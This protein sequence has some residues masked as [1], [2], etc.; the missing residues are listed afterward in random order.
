MAK[1]GPGLPGG[2]ESWIEQHEPEGRYR[3][4]FPTPPQTETHKQ[5]TP[6]GPVDVKIYTSRVPGSDF[7]SVHQAVPADR[8]GL[9][10]DHV[11]DQVAESAR[12]QPGA[13]HNRSTNSRITYP[14]CPP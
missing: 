3:V 13:G 6:A 7:V 11:L 4:K 2:I 8:G 5:Q 1:G 10:D 14:A 9:T 12:A